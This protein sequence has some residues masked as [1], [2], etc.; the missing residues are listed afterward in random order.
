MGANHKNSRTH[1]WNGRA[2]GRKR[3]GKK[4][5][6]KGVGV[7]SVRK[8]DFRLGP[9]GHLERWLTCA[10]CSDWYRAPTMSL[11][12]GGPCSAQARAARQAWKRT[13]Y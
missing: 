6:F 2:F 7:F 1:Q 12:C 10:V 11:T 4:G 9:N 8:V 13:L 5:T 3:S